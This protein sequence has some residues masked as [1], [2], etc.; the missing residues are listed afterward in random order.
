MRSQ[1]GFT[2]IE[3]MMVVA[4][5]GIL[6]I[7]FIGLSARTFGSNADSIGDEVVAQMN[8]AHTRA[9]STR[10]YHCVEVKPQQILVY[11]AATNAGLGLFGMQ[12]VPTACPNPL[13][14]QLVQKM[15]IPTGTTVNDVQ[16]IRA[17]ATGAAVPANGALD[18]LILFKPDGTASAVIGT[19]A[20]IFLTDGT[21]SRRD[22]INLSYATGNVYARKAW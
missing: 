5:I 16:A 7:L 21:G 22:R 3:M 12:A 20:T 15:S 10:R 1:R 18:S 6:S 8:F 2:L 11:Q 9:V 19:G 13:N 4:I 17:T 14:W